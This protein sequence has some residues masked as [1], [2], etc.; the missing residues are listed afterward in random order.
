MHLNDGRVVSNFIVSAL[1]NQ[2]ITIYGEG[3]QTRSFCYVD[4]LIEGMVR[5]MNAPGCYLLTDVQ[6]P[7]WIRSGTTGLARLV[8][9]IPIKKSLVGVKLYTQFFTTDKNANASGFTASNGVRT[10]VGGKK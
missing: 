2:P 7:V 10:D 3:Q 1:T 4:D 6:N 9:Q 8:K 5:F